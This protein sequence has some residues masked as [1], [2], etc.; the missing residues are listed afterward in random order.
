MDREQQLRDEIVHVGRLMYE[1][2]LIVGIDGNISARLGPGRLLITPS[3]VPK[4]S[5]A[6]A[7]LLVVDDE[8]GVPLG[9]QDGLSRGLR[10]TSELPMHLEAYHR[11]PDIEAVVHAHPPV[12]VTLSIANIPMDRGML[13]ESILMVGPIATAPYALPSSEENAAAIRTLIADH[14]AIILQ[15]HGS[16]TVGSSPMQAYL[17]LEAVEQNARI[18]FMLAQLGG[19]DPENAGEPLPPAELERLLAMR[20]RMGLGRPAGDQASGM[21]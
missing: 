20:V 7:D 2:D 12:A 1:K 5:L 13:P 10:P 21:S 18:L 8:S 17:R 4:G 9:R 3:G 6:A 11:R 16:L 19:G 15:R 14:D